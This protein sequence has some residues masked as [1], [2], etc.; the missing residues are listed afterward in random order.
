MSSLINENACQ[1]CNKILDF[2]EKK[3]VFLKLCGHHIC[4]VCKDLIC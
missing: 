2:T 4:C 3:P 1:Q